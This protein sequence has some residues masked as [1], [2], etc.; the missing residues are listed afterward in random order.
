[1]NIVNLIGV[2]IVA[3]MLGI[4]LEALLTQS[5]IR[6]LNENIDVLNKLVAE[7]RKL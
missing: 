4:I 3:F 2:G 5:Y 1:M 6:V 7:L